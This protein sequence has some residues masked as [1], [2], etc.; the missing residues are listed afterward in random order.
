MALGLIKDF[1]NWKGNR[2][3]L[4]ERLA[5][6]GMPPLRSW[7]LE[8]KVLYA[9]RS[10][11]CCLSSRGEISAKRVERKADEWIVGVFDGDFIPVL[12][13][14]VEG[15][16]LR[17]EPLSRGELLD[18]VYS[19]W[20]SRLSRYVD[21]V[22]S[23]E[24]SEYVDDVAVPHFKG[25][26]VA[27]NTYVLEENEKLLSFVELVN[28]FSPALYLMEIR[29][30]DPVEEKLRKK[31]RELVRRGNSKA[32]HEAKR[33][34]ETLKFLQEEGFE[35]SREIEMLSLLIG[36]PEEVRDGS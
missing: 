3:L 30:R 2:E 23:R 8:R 27:K 16:N 26:K 19:L 11:D 21:F 28:G 29:D 14:S 10:L 22:S 6:I 35:F 13:V 31:A 9:M 36:E 15:G 5:E 7:K 34:I 33:L 12:R 4:K 25:S 17:E 32:R 1:E 18:E 20:R 24:M